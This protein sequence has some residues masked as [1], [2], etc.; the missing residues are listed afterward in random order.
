MT[1][2]IH[3]YVVQT[4]GRRYSHM[5]TWNAIIHPN[6]PSSKLVRLT[7]SALIALHTVTG[8]QWPDMGAIEKY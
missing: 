8:H 5:P 3:Q 1:H 6:S 7:T 4:T 2:I